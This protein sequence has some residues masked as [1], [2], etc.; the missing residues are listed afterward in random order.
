M[1]T[2]RTVIMQ[3]TEEK[4]WKVIT[5]IVDSGPPYN[6]ILVWTID[7]LPGAWFCGHVT[8]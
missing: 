3:F 1:I 6:I 5:I 7:L 8:L 4:S 2:R